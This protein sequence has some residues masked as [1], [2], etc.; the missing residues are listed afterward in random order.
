M[1]SA[2]TY[3]ALYARKNVSNYLP[4]I[5]EHDTLLSMELSCFLFSI[6]RLQW[7]LNSTQNHSDFKLFLHMLH[8]VEFKIVFPKNISYA[9]WF[10]WNSNHMIATRFYWPLEYLKIRKF[11]KLHTGTFK[12][13][14]R[15]SAYWTNFE[16]DKN[17]VFI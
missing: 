12:V 14:A 5:L 10:V 2:R 6:W 1:E 17:D 16:K 9:S 4:V 15:R 3:Y 7:N 8:K 11:V 13:L